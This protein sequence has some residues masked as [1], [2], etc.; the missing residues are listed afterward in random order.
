MRFI[1]GYASILI[2]L[3]SLTSVTWAK[4]PAPLF[5]QPVVLDESGRPL[6]NSWERYEYERRQ[7]ILKQKSQS[8]DQSDQTVKQTGQNQTK[9]LPVIDAPVPV[10]EGGTS[11]DFEF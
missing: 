5:D 1:F 11:Q 8:K 10:Q 4:N 7:R 3:M 2:A 9:P 6:Y